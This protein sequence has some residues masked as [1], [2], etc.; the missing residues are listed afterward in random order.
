MEELIVRTPRLLIRP[1]CEEDRGKFIS[2]YERSWGD[3]APWFPLRMPRETFND[4]FD[5]TMVKA[6]KGAADASEF[7]LVGFTRDEQL[8]AFFGLMQIVRG[9]FESAVAS[10]CVHS[11]HTRKGLCTEGVMGVLDMAFAAPPVGLGLHRVQANVIPTN[12]ASVRVAEKAGFRM[13]GLGRNYLKIAGEWRDHVFY[14]K[15][16][17]EH[18]IRYL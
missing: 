8:V 5:R 3:M 16:S 4:T 1:I 17:A 7:R 12:T 9:A 6:K 15:L 11:D 2:F 13:E 14:A 18:Q 10:W